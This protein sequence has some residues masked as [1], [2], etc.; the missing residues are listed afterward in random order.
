V[1]YYLNR[2]EFMSRYS[3]FKTFARKYKTTVSKVIP[4]F[5][6]G[7]EFIL[8]YGV[9]GKQRHM[10]VFKL[11]HMDIRPKDWNVDEIPNILQLVSPRSE[12]V[13]RLNYSKCEYCG[14]TE[15]P[16]ESHHVR[17]VK[18]LSQKKHLAMWE[19]IMITRNR[20]TLVLCRR[21]HKDLHIGKLPDSRYQGN[22]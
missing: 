2:L 1:K 9:K 22:T 11:A 19:R 16:F 7:N 17:K 18:D 13:K 12:L 14:N 8:E 15:P 20:K 5:R 21:C 10:K 6:R 3:L 4:K